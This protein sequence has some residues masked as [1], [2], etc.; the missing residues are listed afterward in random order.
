[1]APQVASQIRTVW[2]DDVDDDETSNSY[3]RNFVRRRISVRSTPY[4]PMTNAGENWHRVSLRKNPIAS[5]NF[6]SIPVSRGCSRG[7]NTNF[8]RRTNGYLPT[9]SKL[10]V[11]YE[12]QSPAIQIWRTDFVMTKSIWEN[13]NIDRCLHTFFLKHLRKTQQHAD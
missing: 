4:L 6:S 8:Q 10:F 11:S 5:R 3:S 7:A 2:A 13:V 9:G 12:R 1:M